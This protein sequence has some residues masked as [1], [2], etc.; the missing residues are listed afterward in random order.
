MGLHY[1]L[2]TLKRQLSGSVATVPESVE[3]AMRDVLLRDTDLQTAM[4]I[5][6]ALC[7]GGSPWARTGVAP[8]MFRQSVFCRWCSIG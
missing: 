7:A 1:H 6:F 3:E 4:D 2:R 5:E 8:S